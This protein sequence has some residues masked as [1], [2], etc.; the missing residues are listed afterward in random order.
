MKFNVT[1]Q[2]CYLDTCGIVKMFLISGL[3]FTFEDEGFDPEDPKIIIQAENNPKITMED[4]YRWS[5]YLIMEE[6]HPIVFNME[7]YIDN[8]Q[9]VPD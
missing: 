1:E 2:Y 4:L 3:P 7:E 5:S 6:C 9:D 8:F